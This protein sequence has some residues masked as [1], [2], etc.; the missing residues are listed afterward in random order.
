MVPPAPPA[1]HPRHSWMILT[2]AYRSPHS[3]AVATASP[4]FTHFLYTLL[5]GLQ[6][7]LP[8]GYWNF[9]GLQWLLKMN[10]DQLQLL[11]NTN[12]DK[13]A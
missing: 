7:D 2:T 4:G 10:H 12:L 6:N 8:L 3:A 13:V 5:M 11:A 1:S 9:K